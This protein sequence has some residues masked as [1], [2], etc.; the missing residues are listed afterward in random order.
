MIS[1]A[2][3][4]GPTPPVEHVAE[5]HV[6]ESLAH[7]VVFAGSVYHC[8]TVHAGQP[9]VDPAPK[10]A[11]FTPEHA[12]DPSARVH[13]ACAICCGERASS[14]WDGAVG[15]TGCGRSPRASWRSLAL[16]FAVGAG[17][18]GVEEHPGI[19][20]VMHAAM[21]TSANAE[22]HAQST[23]RFIG[24]LES[25]SE[26]L[27]ARHLR[28]LNRAVRIEVGRGER[29]PI[30]PGACRA[31]WTCR[32]AFE[33]TGSRDEPTGIV[34]DAT[35]VVLNRS[36]IIHMHSARSP[37]DCARK[38][39]RVDAKLSRVDRQSVRTH[40]DKPCERRRPEDENALRDH[41][42]IDPCV[43]TDGR[44]ERK[45][46]SPDDCPPLHSEQVVQAVDEEL[47]ERA[48]RVE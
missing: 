13:A 12:H 24:F 37:H 41:V 25:L 32:R 3:T 30:G 22:N 1:L 40:V 16:C 46:P 27:C 9:R 15:V 26:E 17:I 45:V 18:S 39:I 28:T 7:V 31:C 33:R 42:S 23:Y 44:H 11:G 10:S 34:P 21:K 48:A 29:A 8:A 43:L 19:S 38:P 4:Q 5:V 6:F 14:L 20:H 2:V 35:R 47:R 36:T